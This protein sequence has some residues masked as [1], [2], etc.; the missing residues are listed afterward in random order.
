MARLTK[1]DSV[2]FLEDEELISGYLDAAME[3]G[4]KE[5][6]LYCISQ[7]LRA[8]AINQL[9]TETGIDR[10]KLCEM[11]LDSGKLTETATKK[12]CKALSAPVAV[13]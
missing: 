5:H 9:V 12:V 11:F 7:A 4:D 2:E 10:D 6:I 3:T 13:S 8:R 1:W